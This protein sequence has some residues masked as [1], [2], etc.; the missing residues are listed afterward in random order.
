MGKQNY[1]QMARESV[2]IITIQIFLFF[3][4]IFPAHHNKECSS[5]RNERG[6]VPLLLF[7]V[8]Q[9]AFEYFTPI[10]HFRD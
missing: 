10:I 4:L 2:L 1:S 6:R 8:W 7:F 5:R 3:N 9:T